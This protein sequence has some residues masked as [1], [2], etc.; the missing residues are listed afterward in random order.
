MEERVTMARVAAACGV[1]VMTVSRALRGQPRV[2]AEVR[3]AVLRCAEELGYRPDPALAALMR[4]RTGKRGQRAHPETLPLLVA[5]EQR[6]AWRRWAVFG[7]MEA[8]VRAEADRLGFRFRLVWVPS[9]PGGLA[10]VLRVLRAR[11]VRGL[12]LT[13]FLHSQALDPESWKD[14]AVVVLGSGAQRLPFHAVRA[15]YFQLC[16]CAV[17]ALRVRGYRRIGYVETRTDELTGQRPLGSLYAEGIVHP[18]TQW[19]AYHCADADPE[20]DPGLWRWVAAERP[21]CLLSVAFISAQAA[22]RAGH[23]VP[24]DLGIAQLNRERGKRN[25]SGV[26]ADTTVQGRLAAQRLHQLLADNQSGIPDVRTIH[27]IDGVW[28][29][30]PTTRPV[31]MR[32]EMGQCH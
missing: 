2:R 23:R 32:G 7:D 18:E 22:A 14:F 10:G 27:R 5:E 12:L 4:Y 24:E 20:S 16:Q 28:H 30:G 26:V 8:G 31:P 21:D 19:L 15:D 13:A 25:Y 1:S 3:E 6:E 9:G 29:D 17:R 11:G